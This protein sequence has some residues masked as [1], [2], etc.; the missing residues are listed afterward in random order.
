M[1]RISYFLLALLTLTAAVSCGDT[2]Q[3]TPTE[4]QP[5]D[6]NTEA[7]TEEAETAHV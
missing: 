7:V 3:N 2:K 1:K 5:K 4:T 6:Q